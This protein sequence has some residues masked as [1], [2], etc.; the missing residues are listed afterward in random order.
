MSTATL[1]K[2]PH[3]WIYRGVAITKEKSGGFTYGWNSKIRH[4]RS[5]PDT[6]KN[7]MKE[8]DEL[9]LNNSVEHCR[10]VMKG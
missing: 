10:I 9:L 1:I 2:T 3:G 5:Y 6:L 8:I 7:T 4:G